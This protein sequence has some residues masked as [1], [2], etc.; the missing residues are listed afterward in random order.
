MQV[1]DDI[2]ALVKDT[3]KKKGCFYVVVKVSTKRVWYAGSCGWD[4]DD[5]ARRHD[6]TSFHYDGTVR[7]SYE[8][9]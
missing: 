2:V 7:T 4:A 9:Y 3:A 5:D 1:P 6:A 8:D